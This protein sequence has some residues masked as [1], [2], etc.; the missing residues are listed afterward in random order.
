[1]TALNQ[2]SDHE[3][4]YTV[5][6]VA[7]RLGIPTATLRSW[8]RRYGIGPRDHRQ[9][10]H[11]LYTEH[12]V[13]VLRRMQQLIDEGVSVGSAAQVAV[14]AP[15][16]EEP[17]TASLLAAAFALDAATAGQLIE[18]R[19]RRGVVDAW[20]GLLRPAFAALT[21]LQDDGGGCIE[22]EHLLSRETARAL[23]RFSGFPGLPGVPVPARQNRGGVIL[24]C[25]G[26]D[27]HTLALEALAAAL[28]QG[29]CAPLMLGA[30]VPADSVLAALSRR[31]GIEAVVLWSQL[32]STADIDAVRSVAATGVRVLVAG[33]GWTR[34]GL[35]RGV[36]RLSTLSVAL[37]ELAPGP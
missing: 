7:D 18:H 12:D 37:E 21:R 17:D 25:C 31:P 29:G 32:E 13:S 16:S 4:L 23:Q 14:G 36:R 35:P 5:G 15:I 24:A 10:R 3:P 22:V 2:L 1:M 27:S 34:R 20:D 30:S 26:G 8:N 6:V 28:A 9:G 33:P 11:R 19:L